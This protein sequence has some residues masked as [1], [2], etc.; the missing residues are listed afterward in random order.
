MQVLIWMRSARKDP[1]LQVAKV[2]KH[3]RVR[4][5]G[6]WMKVARSAPRARGHKDRLTASSNSA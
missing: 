4:G 1:R 2:V 6:E 5:K 3:R